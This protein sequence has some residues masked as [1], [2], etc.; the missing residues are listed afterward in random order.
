MEF[1]E[2][3]AIEDANF[4]IDFEEVLFALNYDLPMIPGIPIV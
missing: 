3:K 1:L 4:Q 2:Q